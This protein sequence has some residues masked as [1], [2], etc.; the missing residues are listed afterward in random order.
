MLAIVHVHVVY[1]GEALQLV[2]L[3]ILV[4]S[5]Y[6]L[7]VENREAVMLALRTDIKQ[8]VGSLC[9]CSFGIGYERLVC[10]GDELL[11]SGNIT[12]K[13]EQYSIKEIVNLINQ[14]AWNEPKLN[15]TLLSGASLSLQVVR[16]AENPVGEINDFSDLENSRAVTSSGAWTCFLLLAS[17][18]THFIF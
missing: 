6:F 9:D 12:G 5:K 4:V 10:V 15:T 7:Q 11:Y 3:C 17:I 18:V 16:P 1:W 14:W 13:P 2:S 8:V